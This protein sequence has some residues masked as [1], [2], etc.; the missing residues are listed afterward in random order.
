[1]ALPR[2]T[3]KE[4][5]SLLEKLSSDIS[6][7]LKKNGLTIDTVVPIMRGGGVP[8]IYLAYAL[9]V[10]S[11][12]PVHY[13]YDFREKGKMK[14]RRFITIKR[15]IDLIPKNPVI[16]LVEGNQCFGNTAN[17][18][19]EDI[20]NNIKNPVVLYAADLVD[21]GYKDAVKAD[22]VFIGKYSNEC[23]TLSHKE[24]RKKGIFPGTKLLPWEIEKEEKETIKTKQFKYRDLK[25]YFT[26]SKVVK[27]IKINQETQ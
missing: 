8:G 24:A 7:H 5:E 3:W 14:L 10:L 12:L 23:G 4:Y 2:F 27:E 20:K 25:Q 17:A 22:A 19:L 16:L 15:Y 11:I 9:H 18:A 26:K 6:K 13:H 1:M 21:Y